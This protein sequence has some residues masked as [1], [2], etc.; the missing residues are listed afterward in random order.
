MQAGLEKSSGSYISIIDADM[1]QKPSTLISMYNKLIENKDYDVVCAYRESRDDD[2]KIK[3]IIAPLFYKL[4]N[5][6][7]NVNL[8]SGASDFRVFKKEVKDAII[9]LKENNRFLKENGEPT[10]IRAS[11]AIKEVYN[12]YT[13]VLKSFYTGIK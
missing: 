3:A 13:G 5:K 9:S 2:N 6:V 12:Y 10:D 7:S 4:I 1:Q 11:D 8:V